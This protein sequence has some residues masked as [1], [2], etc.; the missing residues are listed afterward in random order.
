[1]SWLLIFR[2]SLTSVLV[3]LL[4]V[5]QFGIVGRSRDRRQRHWQRKV[6]NEQRRRIGRYYHNPW[7]HYSF[8]NQCV[9]Q[10]SPW[11]GPRREGGNEA[12]LCHS[13][14]PKLT[15]CRFFGV[16]KEYFSQVRQAN[17]P[18]RRLSVG[19]LLS[20]LTYTHLVG[21]VWI[22]ENCRS[23]LKACRSCLCKIRAR[24]CINGEKISQLNP[25]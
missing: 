23:Q 3:S 9:R 18:L 12:A 16:W 21:I 1:M 19:C 14:H 5:W 6:K 7:S 22:T 24:T 11:T 10:A 13:A 8:M 20:R 4:N 17:F 2:I 15:Q 25:F